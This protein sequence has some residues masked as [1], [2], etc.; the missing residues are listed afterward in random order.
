MNSKTGKRIAVIGAGP[1]GLM[2]A[3]IACNAGMSVDVYERMGSVGRKFLV[4]G[5]GGLNLTHSEPKPDFVSRFGSRQLEISR[6]LEHFD[7]DAVRTWARG[8]GVETF[9]GSSGRIF[10][11]D[12][13]AAPL[14]RGWVRRLRA[15]GVHFHVHHRWQGWNDSGELSFSTDSGEQQVEADAVVLALGGGSWSILG[16][17]G[18]WQDTLAR[19]GIE[20]AALQPSNCGF[21]IDWSPFLRDRHA[22]APIKPV[23]IQWTS[24]EGKSICR[25]GEFVLTRDGV[26]GSLIYALSSELREAIAAQGSTT[27]H[28]DLAPDRD[29]DRLTRDLSRPRGSHSMSKHLH[30]NA[31]IDGAKAALLHEVLERSVFSDPAQ[32]ASAIK[33]LPLRLLRPRPIDEAISSAG[34]VR[35]EVLDDQLMSSA[36]PGVFCAG[37]MLDWEAPTG[38]YLLTASLAS[39]RI[40]GAG[41]VDWL[42]SRE[43]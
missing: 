43:A 2:A 14:L 4:A 40:A 23:T 21:D 31:G 9:V 7:A 38:G 28:L 8:L 22:G 26:E 10:P 32:L 13:K 11:A 36:L 12:L 18:A 24:A 16:S 35:L 20:V 33:L 1:A 30:R 37:E 17:D 19:R 27:I 6:W 34:G 3:E 15:N 42:R 25:Q 5:K 41:A 29:L 39:G